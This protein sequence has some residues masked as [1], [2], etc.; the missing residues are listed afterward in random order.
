M[1][2][3][4]LL[5]PPSESKATP[6][7]NG[8]L[9]KNARANRKTNSFKE[10][11]KLRGM[12]IDEVQGAIN[13][14]TGLDKLF[15]VSGKSLKEA[16]DWNDRIMEAT[17]LPARE[18]Y[19]GVMW[20]AIN[21]KTLK[22]EEKKRFDKNT[23][24]FSG[25]FGVLRPTDK[26][27]AYKLKIGANMGGAVGRIINY[28]KRPVSEVLRKELRSKVVWDFLPDQHKRVWDN[29]GEVKARHQVKFVK[30]IIRSGVAEYK[31]I[32]HHSKALKGALIRHLL[33]KDAASPKDLNDFVH[34]DG[35]RFNRDL[36]VIDRR[37]SLLVFA[38]D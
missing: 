9:Y 21:Y 24:I 30:R 5:I 22:A 26:I 3:W 4:V 31:T 37:Q 20:E 27:P 35:Y 16:I 6:P 7:A 2:N 23:I 13:R 28:W 11:D 19:T 34:P 36:S 33:A 12:L 10:L 38:A 32:S 1:S 18:L 17:T 25:L 14:G 15:E 29:T 8:A